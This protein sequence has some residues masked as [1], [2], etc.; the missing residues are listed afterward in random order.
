MQAKMAK[1]KLPDAHD[2]LRE[3]QDGT[4]SLVQ[5][6]PVQYNEEFMK[7]FKFHAKTES[8]PDEFNDKFDPQAFNEFKTA[9]LKLFGLDPSTKYEDLPLHCVSKES[10]NDK[11]LFVGTGRQLMSLLRC[12]KDIREELDIESLVEPDGFQCRSV[13]KLENR[14]V[15]VFHLELTQKYCLYTKC[16]WETM[17]CVKPKAIFDKECRI[18]PGQEAPRWAF[19]SEDPTYVMDIDWF[20]CEAYKWTLWSAAFVWTCT[21][22]TVSLRSCGIAWQWEW[23][24]HPA[25]LGVATVVAGAFALYADFSVMKWCIVPWLQHVRKLEYLGC[26]T[27]F[28]LFVTIQLSSTALQIFT[29]QNNAWFMVSAFQANDNVLEYWVYLWT[30][31]MFNFCPE[32]TWMTV[33]TPRVLAICLWFLSTGQLVLPVLFG[34]P[35]SSMPSPLSRL[36]LRSRPVETQ[37]LHDL[38]RSFLAEEP[39]LP[40]DHYQD[41]ETCGSRMR[42]CLS[43]RARM[44][45]SAGK[46]CT[47]RESVA[48]L[49]LASGLRYTSSM[50][51]SYPKHRIDE[52]IQFTQGFKVRTDHGFEPLPQGWELRSIKEFQKLVRVL[53]DRVHII[54][55]FK[56]ALQMNLQITF[57]LI[58]RIMQK[59]PGGELLLQGKIVASD[60]AGVV[61]IMSLLFTFGTE[62]YDVILVIRIFCSVRTA[63][64]PGLCKAKE[65]GNKLYATDHFIADKTRMPTMIEYSGK[66]LRNEFSAARKYVVR[67]VCATLLSI[68]LIGYALL[69]GVAAY[70]CESGAWQL[71]TG[72]LDPMQDVQ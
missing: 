22:L 18:H 64:G 66:D 7:A 15:K 60:L 72:C 44:P 39:F 14:D 31:S 70:I 61:S 37:D 50:S 54:M 68:W 42:N 41:F 8:D 1:T 4:Y 63:V 29:I 38:T 40:E 52:I 46:K 2:F 65:D 6:W 9:M 26:Q 3:L 11:R 23:V 20:A 51:I 27:P 35:C 49:A 67:M 48:K 17:A 28:L 71:A 30:N 24:N 56:L 58:R 57:I 10:K 12:A 16:G 32:S 69:K 59:R 62:L 53:L 47:Y 13:D 55:L 21:V 34:V 33:I 36:R 43:L 25:L 5:A 19:A 45:L